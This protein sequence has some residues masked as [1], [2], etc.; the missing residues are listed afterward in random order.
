MVVGFRVYVVFRVDA[1]IYVPVSI[2]SDV[3]KV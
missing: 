1:W 2:I 3:E